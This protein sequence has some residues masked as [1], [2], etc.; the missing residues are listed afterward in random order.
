MTECGLFLRQEDSDPY[1]VSLKLVH[2]IE[3][4][5]PFQQDEIA[6]V[7]GLIADAV[8]FQTDFH[9]H[10]SPVFTGLFVLLFFL[11]F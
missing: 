2:S 1:L 3:P 7:F 11:G 6:D 10:D 4:Y 9:F 8:L 5:G